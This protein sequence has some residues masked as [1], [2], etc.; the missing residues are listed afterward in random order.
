M[1]QAARHSEIDWLRSIGT[2][3]QGIV[4]VSTSV[5]FLIV[6][7]IVFLG[8]GDWGLRGWIRV[9]TFPGRETFNW[10]LRLGHERHAQRHGRAVA[11]HA[12]HFNNNCRVALLS[13]SPYIHLVV[14]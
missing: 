10:P 1:S 9:E 6:S 2:L 5:V 14:L 8:V 11:S 7:L 13:P 12:G 4:W 3:I